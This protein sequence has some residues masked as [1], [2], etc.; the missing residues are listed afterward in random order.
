M[1]KLFEIIKKAKEDFNINMHLTIEKGL[2]WFI[3]VH[4]P[5][6]Y[7]FEDSYDGYKTVMARVNGIKDEKEAFSKVCRQLESW[8]E[9][10]E[11][12]LIQFK[13]WNS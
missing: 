9:K 8:I 13:K 3:L 6:E 11:K 4:Y 12:G 1:E 10:N 2:D 7:F 5:G